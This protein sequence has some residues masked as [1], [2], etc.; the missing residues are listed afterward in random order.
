MYKNEND[1]QN[2]INNFVDKGYELLKESDWT[3]FM[4][5]R[6]R[7]GHGDTYMERH[8]DMDT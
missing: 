3:R 8:A 5:H 6:H 4:L 2:I 7:H 1:I